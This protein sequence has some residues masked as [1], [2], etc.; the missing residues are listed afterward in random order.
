MICMMAV[1][2]GFTQLKVT[3]WL[4]VPLGAGVVTH[5]EHTLIIAT[6]NEIEL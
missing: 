1:R 3:W 6:S 4:V 5:E 2:P